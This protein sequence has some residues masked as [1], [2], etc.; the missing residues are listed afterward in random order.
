MVHAKVMSNFMQNGAAY[1]LANALGVSKAVVFDGTLVNGDALWKHRPGMP[2]RGQWNALIQAQEGVAFF[3]T[4]A[5]EHFFIGFAFYQ[6]HQICHLFME[7]KG[8]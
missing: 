8:D 3:H 4:Y 7:L 5:P 1:L 6:Y 2:L